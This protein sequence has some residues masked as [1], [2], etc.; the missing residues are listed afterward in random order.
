MINKFKRI[1]LLSAV[2]VSSFVGVAKAAEN[3]VL[4]PTHTNIVWHANHFGFS[5]PSG[6]FAKVEGTLSLDENKPENSAVKV[7]IS[8]ASISTGFDKFDEHLKSKDFFNIEKFPNATFES[9]KVEVLD[10]NNAKVS[11]K[12][13]IL[14]VSKPVTLDVRLNQIGNHPFSKKKTAGFSATTAIKRSDFG[15]TYGI[16]GVSDEVKISIETEASVQ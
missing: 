11:G 9:E 7:T 5:T 13:T 6:K 4:D 12:L 2:S 3:Y 15:M 10:K 16:P 1:I 14:G 8:T